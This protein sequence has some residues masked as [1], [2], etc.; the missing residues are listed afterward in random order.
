ME[1]NQQHHQQEVIGQV[2]ERPDQDNFHVDDISQGWDMEGMYSQQQCLYIMSVY[3][4][5][6]VDMCWT[7]LLE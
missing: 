2:Q 5:F 3:I 7:V 6:V 1:Q 4:Q